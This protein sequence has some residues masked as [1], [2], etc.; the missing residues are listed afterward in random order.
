MGVADG[1]AAAGDHSAEQRLRDGVGQFVV[2]RIEIPV[3][4]VHHDVGDA[5]GHLIHRQR[6]GQLRVHDG[7]FGA[8][9][10]RGQA[11]L[12]PGGKVGQ[13]GGIAGLA[14]RRGNREDDA[15]RQ[16]R[17]RNALAAPVFPDVHGGV[18]GA[19]GN[20]LGGVN[21]GAAAHGQ[22][23]I[24]LKFDGGADAVL[25]VVQGRIRFRASEGLVGQSRGIQQPAD[26][27]Q[28]AAFLNAAAAIDD[29]NAVSPVFADIVSGTALG[30]LAEN[31]LC[32]T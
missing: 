31:D 16:R 15:H 6:I 4:R 27:L 11:A 19:D 14:A 23:E 28:Q 8:V 13:H 2:Q 17:G 12:A 29:E 21:G 32:G 9:Q 26:L 30:I 22:N 20:G 25:R 18:G 10:I 5:A 24:R 1:H 7:K 3:Q